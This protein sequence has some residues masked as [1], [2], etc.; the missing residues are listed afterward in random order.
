MDIDHHQRHNTQT[1]YLSGFCGGPRTSPRTLAVG[2]SYCGIHSP[3]GYSIY[4]C[5]TTVGYTLL[6]ATD[7]LSCRLQYLSLHYDCRIHSP[8]GYSIYHCTTTV[9]YT[10]LQATDTL[11]CR[12]QYLSL[13]YD[14]NPIQYY[15]TNWIHSPAGYSIYHCTTTVGYTLLQA[16]DTLSC[17]LQ[18][19][20]LHYD[21]RIHSPA[22]YSTYHCTTTVGYTLLQATDT[23][24]CRLQYLSLHYDCRI[25]S[26]AGYST[27]HCTTT[28]GYTLLQATVT[29]GYTLL[30]AT[31]TVGYILLQATVSLRI[32]HC[33]HRQTLTRCY[34]GPVGF[35]INRIKS[36]LKQRVETVKGRLID[37]AQMAMSSGDLPIPVT[38]D[39]IPRNSLIIMN[40]HSLKTRSSSVKR[41][42]VDKIT[43]Y[44]K[45]PQSIQFET[46]FKRTK[47]LAP[48]S[49]KR[50]PCQR[51][52]RLE[53]NHGNGWR[54]EWVCVSGWRTRTTGAGTSSSRGNSSRACPGDPGSRAV[55]ESGVASSSCACQPLF[56]LS[57]PPLYDCHRLLI[58]PCGLAS[59]CFLL[60]GV[61]LALSRFICRDGRLVN[62]KNEG[63]SAPSLLDRGSLQPA[64]IYIV[65]N[66]GDAGVITTIEADLDA[67]R[68][69]CSTKSTD[70][71]TTR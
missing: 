1:N 5:T 44:N 60:L 9:G 8:A 52:V 28:V 25:H 56:L 14:C 3:A 51:K 2:Y 7:T 53:R 24:S 45:H 34:G 30:Q 19:L 40:V 59:S 50:C 33:T 27:Y 22:G 10:L 46:T 67:V 20:S 17:R 69:R 64:L 6:Q 61:L 68:F 63:P 26:P 55:G 38:V 16:T 13:H 32:H 54:T 37:P 71:C 4:H 21:C 42:V 36:K 47:S 23:L 66:A 57:R 15:L 12:L 29:V 35:L 70:Y 41:I 39:L 48:S 49:F 31:V 58:S 11:S 62:V 18:Y 43:V 65:S